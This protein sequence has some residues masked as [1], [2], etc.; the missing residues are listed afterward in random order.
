[1]LLGALGRCLFGNGRMQDIYQSLGM[2]INL[3]G[4]LKKYWKM[5]AAQTLRTLG[6]KLSDPLV[7]FMWSLE[8]S[9]LTWLDVKVREG[10]WLSCREL[11]FEMTSLRSAASLKPYDFQFAG[12]TTLTSSPM[13]SCFDPITGYHL[14]YSLKTLSESLRSLHNWTVFP[15]LTHSLS[16]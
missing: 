11:S 1:M 14:G 3:K 10:E 9:F 13:L 5:P 8:S 7:F 15:F 16:L 6:V 4:R 12:S 2:I